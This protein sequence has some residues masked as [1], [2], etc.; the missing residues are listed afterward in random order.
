[1]AYKA[2]I[3]SKFKQQWKNYIWQSLLVVFVLFV[4]VRALGEKKIVAISSMGATAFIVFAMPKSVSAK[5]RNVI[6]GH[7]VGLACGAVFY[8]TAMPYWAEYPL[9]VGL[10]MLL[11]VAFD[12]E[13]PP[14]AGTALAVVISEVS[15]DAFVTIMLTAVILT[16]CRHHLK[17]YLKNLV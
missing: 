6:G 10:A 9:A 8:F 15:P 16:Q 17:K 13:H 11:M 7:L 12:G 4:V 3:A 5:T 2:Q 1:M 14:A